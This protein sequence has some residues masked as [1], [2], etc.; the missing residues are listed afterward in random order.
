MGEGAM[1][2]DRSFPFGGD[3]LTHRGVNRT[4]NKNWTAYF[5]VPHHLAMRLK[6][7]ANAKRIA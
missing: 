5:Y 1:L 2:T 7:D 4:K 3:S 6:S